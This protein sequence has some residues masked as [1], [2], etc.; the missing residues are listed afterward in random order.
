V[1]YSYN[2]EVRSTGSAHY[3]M[4]LKMAG[5]HG[6]SVKQMSN[7]EQDA[8]VIKAKVTVH[9]TEMPCLSTNLILQCFT[10][11]KVSV[12]VTPLSH[13][14]YERRDVSL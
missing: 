8:P 1:F 4:V 3:K 6:A 14:P 5:N 10:L 11:F 9:S 7:L 13:F 2:E 12:N